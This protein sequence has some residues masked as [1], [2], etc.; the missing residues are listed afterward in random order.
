MTK[1]RIRDWVDM[2]GKDGVYISFSGGKD[3]T[4]LLDIVRNGCGFSEIPAVF[5]DTGL[6]FP[7]IKEFVK[8]FDNVEIIRPKM[9]FKQVVEKYGYPIISKE[10]S[11]TIFYA[12]RHI[13]NAY[14]DNYK[15]VC[16]KVAE[17]GKN[18]SEEELLNMWDAIDNVR[19]QK[20]IGVLP[21]EGMLDKQKLH[22]GGG[23]DHCLTALN[24]HL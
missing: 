8:S 2:Y 15:E 3:S 21:N 20:L 19:V 9:T 18:P 23:N 14:P 1:R 7:E 17:L 11:N 16:E 4:V 5:S 10:V 12:R 6:E 24:G 22:T 13:E